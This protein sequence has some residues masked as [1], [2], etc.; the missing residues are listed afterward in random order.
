MHT[1]SQTGHVYESHHFNRRLLHAWSGIT[2][3]ISNRP[4]THIPQC[5]SHIS[6]NAPFCN[7]NV[8]LC[9]HFCYKMVHCGIFWIYRSITCI[10]R[11]TVDQTWGQF[12]Q[13]DISF[14][15]RM[16]KSPCYISCTLYLH[17]NT[18]SYLQNT[19]NR[20]PIAPPNGWAMGCL[21]W[22]LHLIYDLWL[23]LL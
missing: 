18:I 2:I 19:Y 10:E 22:A 12:C 21:L 3:V 16:H 20:H 23:S 13:N 9:A 1:K 15:M 6:H 17:Y 7:R 11:G 14:S 8:H 4:I 5:T